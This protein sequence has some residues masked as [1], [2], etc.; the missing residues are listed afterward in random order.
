MFYCARHC[1]SRAGARSVIA[2]ARICRIAARVASSE[3]NVEGLGVGPR[4]ICVSLESAFMYLVAV[5]WV[6][7]PYGVGRP[8]LTSYEPQKHDKSHHSSYMVSLHIVSS[9]RK[10]VE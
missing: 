4:Y 3:F 6:V 7:N 8:I 10:F 5:V 9:F 1:I 2:R